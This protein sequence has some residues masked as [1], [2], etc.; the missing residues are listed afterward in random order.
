MDSIP[1]EFENLIQNGNYNKFV[2]FEN[3]TTDG[4]YKMSRLY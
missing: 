4:N 2:E 3:S 1:F